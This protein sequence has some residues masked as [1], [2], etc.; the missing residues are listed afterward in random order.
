MKQ[1]TYEPTTKVSAGYVAS[2][3]TVLTLWMVTEVI[4]IPMSATEAGA[5]VGVASFALS[6]LVEE[7]G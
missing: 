2:C 3:A 4:G 6:Y 7:K 1:P 5:L